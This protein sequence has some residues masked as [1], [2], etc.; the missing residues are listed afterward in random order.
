[1]VFRSLGR[2]R[3]GWDAF[4]DRYAYAR[5]DGEGRSR[6]P[7]AAPSPCRDP[8]GWLLAADACVP[9]TRRWRAVTYRGE[10]CAAGRVAPF[11]TATNSSMVVRR[12]DIPSPCEAM[13]RRRRRRRRGQDQHLYKFPEERSA[14]ATV[15]VRRRHQIRA[16]AAPHVTKRPPPP[17]FPCGTGRPS[18]P[19]APP[20]PSSNFSILDPDNQFLDP[21]NHLSGEGGGG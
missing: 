20:Q 15:G 2:R 5:E 1:M 3:L 12:S 9:A 6:R 10:D 17:S 7:H 14:Y 19:P 11:L 21:Q 8:E 18:S 13:R 4:P 16:L